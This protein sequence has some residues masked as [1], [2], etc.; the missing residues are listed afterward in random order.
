LDGR[1]PGRGLRV[2][3][4]TIFPFEIENVVAVNLVDTL[5][6]Y[7]DQEGVRSVARVEHVVKASVGRLVDGRGRRVP[8]QLKRSDVRLSRSKVRREIEHTI[9]MNNVLAPLD[10]DHVVA[11]GRLVLSLAEKYA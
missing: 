5:D 11:E 4:R 7:D 6:H 1:A 2:G 9:G 8:E 10:V 3:R